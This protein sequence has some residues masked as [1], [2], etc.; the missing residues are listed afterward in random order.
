MHT[1]KLR[2]EVSIHGLTTKLWNILTCSE[3]NSQFLVEGDIRCDWMKD[4]PILVKNEGR[5]FHARGVV[6]EVVPG[7]LLRFTLFGIEGLSPDPLH[8]LYEIF[9]RENGI[10]LLLTLEFHREDLYQRVSSQTQMMLQKI[11]WL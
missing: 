10:I 4:S 2:H 6:N 3:Y 1:L 11:K 9:P 8:F 5:E 7:I